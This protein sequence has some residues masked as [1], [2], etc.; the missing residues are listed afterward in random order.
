MEVVEVGT[1]AGT[2]R[3]PLMSE[4]ITIGRAAENDVV[5]ADDVACS[6]VHA[7]LRRVDVG[8]VV[9]DLG[10][11][12]GTY[13]NGARLAAPAVLGPKD[14][15]HLGSATLRLATLPDDGMTAEEP[16]QARRRRQQDLLLSDR[17]KEVLRL[18]AQG[19]TDEQIGGEL[20]INVKT[21]HSHLDHIKDKTGERR[22]ADLT[23]L[24]LRLGLG[25]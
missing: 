3:I 22:R 8:W 12:N 24:A 17:E 13:V 20:Y 21:V 19:R 2:T 9:E 6:R 11:R 18:V 15:V 10:S 1:A 14:I 4:Q 16:E 23:R 25:A 5:L 7:T